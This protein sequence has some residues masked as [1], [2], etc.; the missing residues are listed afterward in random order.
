MADGRRNRGDTS[1]AIRVIRG[2]KTSNKSALPRMF[3]LS[4]LWQG[5]SQSEH[6]RLCDKLSLHDKMS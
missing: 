5:L 2:P 6:D 4:Q 1:E 3:S